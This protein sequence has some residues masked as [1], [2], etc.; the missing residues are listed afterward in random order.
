[1]KFISLLATGYSVVDYAYART[2]GIPVANVP[3]YG[4]ASV[5]QFSIALLLEICHHIG[6]HDASVH[7]GTW[8]NCADCPVNICTTRK[9]P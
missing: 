3:T 7:A 1:M 9:M 6:H 2:K 4:T 5:S 8:A